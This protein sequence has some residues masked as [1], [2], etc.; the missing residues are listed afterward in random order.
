MG[1]C[2]LAS[3]LQ[4]PRL[5]SYADACFGVTQKFAEYHAD[6][7]FVYLLLFDFSINAKFIYYKDET[8]CKLYYTLGQGWASQAVFRV[9][10]SPSPFVT[11]S[12]R[13][14]VESSQVVFVICLVCV[15]FY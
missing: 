5:R 3:Y 13:V 2:S 7:V 15:Y 10:S 12:S 11:A 4:P 1:G 8:L 6:M 14:R 9:E